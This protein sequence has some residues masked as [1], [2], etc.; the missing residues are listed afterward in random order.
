MQTPTDND[1]L[2]SSDPLD[3]GHGSD[4]KP[5]IREGL[6]PKYRM[7][8]DAHYVEQLDASLGGP[9]IRC[10]SVAAIDTGPHQPGEVLPALVDS[11]ARCGILQPLLVQR[12]NGETRLIDGRKRLKAAIAAGLRE[13]PCLI[14]DVDDRESAALA[15]GA[16][17]LH[18]RTSTVSPG[19]AHAQGLDI[20]DALT[21]AVA[22]IEASTHLLS[23]S[24]SSLLISVGTDLI[25]AGAWRTSCLLQASSIVQHGVPPGQVVCSARR[26]V[27]S[28][29]EKAEAE[30]RLRGYLLHTEHEIPDSLQIAGDPS[31]LS[32]ALSAL[33]LATC[34]VIEGHSGIRITLTA[35]VDFTRQIEFAVSEVGIGVSTDWGSRAFDPT[36]SNRPG[37]IAAAVWMLAA[38]T[39]AESYGGRMSASGTGRGT[40]I[41]MVM[42]IAAA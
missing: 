3:D 6:P 15:E 18:S 42:P 17:V 8:A 7:R 10:L 13:V 36:W 1:L 9:M 24:G 20:Y 30:R 28:V 25:R 33:L 32:T 40:T 2:Q 19:P 35:S 41:K 5:A 23:S 34:A 38:R 26:L 37:G 27:T 11:V 14:H 16:N 21:R 4:S 22:D 12:R 29:A 39:I 31:N